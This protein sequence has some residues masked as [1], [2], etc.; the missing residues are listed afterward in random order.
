MGYLDGERWFANVYDTNG[1]IGGNGPG[2]EVPLTR[3][4][5]TNKQT[6]F[7]Y[8]TKY[9]VEESE[10]RYAQ[11]RRSGILTT[12]Y[13]TR[14]LNDWVTRIGTKYYQMELE[15]WYGENSLQ[16]AVVN[17][18]YWE[19]VTDSNGDYVMANNVSYD[20]QAY[21]QVGDIV[22]VGF[23]IV[24]S[25]EFLT[26]ESIRNK[27]TGGIYTFKCIQANRG[28]NPFYQ[29][30]YADNIWRVAKWFD[31]QFE[32]MDSVYNFTN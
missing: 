10:A 6:P 3:H 17:D 19:I 30:T 14:K 25:I 21:Y 2:S 11:L 15:K 16:N 31:K 18:T 13:I 22:T 23:Q 5:A 27:N 8:T 29:M 12:E 28:I 9:Y 24:Q 4:R 20:M 1:A 26:N 7:F 32:N